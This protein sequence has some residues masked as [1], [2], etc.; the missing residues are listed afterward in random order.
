MGEDNQKSKAPQY[1]K[2]GESTTSIIPKNK[3]WPSLVG[4]T[5]EEAEKK[6]K[7]EMPEVYVTV[8]PPNHAITFDLRFNRV[9]LFVD[10]SGKVR[11]T[12]SIG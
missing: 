12:P 5:A 2:V 1:Q 4:L 6:I 9:W 7:E 3:V 8:V 11:Q 10:S